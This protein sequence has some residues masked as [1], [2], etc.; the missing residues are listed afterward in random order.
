MWTQPHPPHVFGGVHLY[1]HTR[2]CRCLHGFFDLHLIVWR[3]GLSLS[4]RLT[5]LA[6]L[7]ASEPQGVPSLSSAST[8]M[9]GICHQTWPSCENSGLHAL[10]TSSSLTEPFPQCPLPLWVLVFSSIKR[11]QSLGL[12]NELITKPLENSMAFGKPSFCFHYYY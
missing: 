4:P 12:L 1:V 3:K 7:A 5:H 6:R 10:V 2:V 11:G 9:I 8:V